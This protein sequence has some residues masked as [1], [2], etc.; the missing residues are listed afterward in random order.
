MRIAL[1]ILLLFSSVG[2]RA[3]EPGHFDYW[4]LS[5]SWSPQYCSDHERDPQCV[6]AYA[7]VVHGLWPQNDVG[8][9][10]DCGPSESVNRALV[11]RMLPLMP[12]PK[13]IQHE[14]RTHGVCS[15][16]GM[17]DYFLTV[18]R[19]YRGISIPQTYRDPDTY[20]STSA[21]EIQRNFIAANPGLTPERMSLQCS[22]RYLKEVR[23]CYDK[24]FHYR[25][26]GDDMQDRCRDQI[27]LR[28]SR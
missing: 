11:E 15:G 7:F 17:E 9:P 24:S 19:A 27:V 5:L 25:D 26:C 20:L 10:Q 6:R 16:L 13:L 21:K 12:N 1:A 4:V 2:A 28:P 22:G 23:I 18:E 8:Y 3:H 14:W